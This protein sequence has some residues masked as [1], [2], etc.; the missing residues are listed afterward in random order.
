MK[1]KK[2]NEKKKTAN[3]ETTMTINISYN[4]TLM[5]RLWCTAGRHPVINYC[6][7]FGTSFWILYAVKTAR[8]SSRT[9]FIINFR[10]VHMRVWTIKY[11][12]ATEGV[13]VRAASGRT[14]VLNDSSQSGP[15]KEGR[16]K[17]LADAV[18]TGGVDLTNLVLAR[19]LNKLFNF[20]GIVVQART[21]T[22]RTN[23]I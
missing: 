16:K 1:E 17:N 6:Y 8:W 21:H 2:K 9:A 23:I 19:G 15:G 5:I 20:C 13:W 4:I 3:S 10:N 12:D 18:E 7:G 22:H 11:S 14:R